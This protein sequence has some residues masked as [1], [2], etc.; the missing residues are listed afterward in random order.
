MKSFAASALLAIVVTGCTGNRAPTAAAPA[1]TGASSQALEATEIGVTPTE[2]HVAVIADVDTPL[3][4]GLSQ[5]L[6]SAVQKW[7]DRVN[8]A[9]GLAGRKVIVDFYDSK[10]NPD[11]A[12]SAFLQACQN[13]FA[14]VGTGAFTM[15]NPDPINNCADKAGKTTGLPDLS[16]LSISQ[17]QASAKSN[18]GLILASQNF[19][20]DGAPYIVS[21]YGWD[22]YQQKLGGPPKVLALNPGVPGTKEGADVQLMAMEKRGWTNAGNVT[23]SDVAPQSQATPIVNRIKNEGINLVWSTSIGIGK[24]MAEA[25]IQGVDMSKVIWVCTSQCETPAFLKQNPDADGVY[26]SQLLTPPS[27]TKVTGVA[28]YIKDV[29]VSDQSANGEAAYGVA[30]AF[31]ELIGKLVA[32]KGPNG[33]TRQNLL[34]LMASNPA[35][36]AQGILDSKTVLGMPTNCWVTA[37]AKNGDFARVDP[38]DSGQFRCSDSATVTL[39]V[40]TTH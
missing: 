21:Q 32:D 3:S 1:A 19:K 34:T 23:F 15:Q 16:A 39:P 17:G 18:Y 8:A 25:K 26:V 35:V 12:V 20:A 4:P 29:P 6:V 33:L 24:I 13:D 38:P 2:L 40:P 14:T 11:N 28:N 22:Y 36:S 7:G 9:G 37:Q 10:L 30:L 27:D 31:Q 5:P